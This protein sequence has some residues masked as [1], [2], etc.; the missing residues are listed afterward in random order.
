MRDLSRRAVA[1][2]VGLWLVAVAAFAAAITLG[3]DPRR[4]VTAAAEPFAPVLTP[5]RA[6]ATLAAAVADVRLGR[7]LDGILE[8]PRLGRGRERS[9]LVVRQAG[10]TVY[11]R[12]PTEPLVP[13]SNMKVL[14]ALAVLR[15]LGADARF[16]T[17]V[18][19][20]RPPVN[21]IV[22]G[23]LH[24]VGSG[25]PL[26]ATADY[27]AHFPNQPQLVTPLEDL[28]DRI[29][30]AGIREVRGRVLGDESRF[31]RQRSIPTWAPNYVTDGETGAHSALVVNDTF[32][33][34]VPKGQAA[35]EPAAHAAGVLSGLLRARGVTVTGAPDDG[36]TPENAVVVASIDSPPIGQIVGQMLRES[37]NMTAELLVKELGRRFQGRG[38]TTDGVAV[39]RATLQTAG[40]PAAEVENV[41][42]SGLD[43]LDRATCRVLVDALVA[44]PE[45]ATIEAGLPVA[46]R[47]GTL[48]ERFRGH[49]AAG[50][51]RAKTG[52]LNFVTGL[53][54]WA[55]P[56]RG[57]PLA[58]SL[59]ANDLPDRVAAGRALQERVSGALVAYPEAPDAGAL[60]PRPPR[61]PTSAAP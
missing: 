30:D 35:P 54:G 15:R 11:E 8:D 46:G 3:P 39:L 45:R 17:E 57:D 49:P 5:R 60:A 36:P 50:R 20:G 44:A 26:I 19:A 22:D 25:D 58:F 7:R 34:W 40:L 47:S 55:D 29:R 59:L 10:R 23:D 41:D 48:A 18:R 2:A 1:L 31:D 9:C 21:G 33:S 52:S 38:T 61:P 53:T 28:A 27:A 43:R 42:G 56:A 6:P 16:R 13:A 24:L 37:D 4:P 51:V 14:T 12:R 32:V